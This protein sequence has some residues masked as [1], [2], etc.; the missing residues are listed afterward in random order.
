MAIDESWA[1]SAWLWLS[2]L[3]QSSGV[4]VPEG[5]PSALTK[6]LL[7]SL[8][9][10]A[11]KVDR[12]SN[13]YVL[14]YVIAILSEDETLQEHEE[15]LLRSARNVDSSI[16]EASADQLGTTVA[17]AVQNLRF[18]PE[19][20]L[21]LA[22]ALER[23]PQTPAVVGSIR[24]LNEHLNVPPPPPPP[25]IAVAEP[26]VAPHPALEEDTSAAE[27]EIG[28]AHGSHGDPWASFCSQYPVGS[29]MQ[30][31][32]TGT[33]EYGAFINLKPGID[34]LLHTSEMP[35]RHGRQVLDIV[36]AGQKVTIR[37]IKFDQE[38]HRISLSMKDVP[39]QPS[40]PESPAEKIAGD[41]QGE[42]PDQRLEAAKV[43]MEAAKHFLTERNGTAR[44]LLREMA[45]VKGTRI[46]GIVEEQNPKKARDVASALIAVFAG[47]ALT[48]PLT[49]PQLEIMT[50]A[51]GA[52]ADRQTTAVIKG[53]TW[54]SNDG[55]VPTPAQV[56]EALDG[57]RTGGHE[58]QDL[59]VCSLVRALT[60]AI[61]EEDVTK[62]TRVVDVAVELGAELPQS[63]A[64]ELVDLLSSIKLPTTTSLKLGELR[65]RAN[66][67]NRPDV[68]IAEQVEGGIGR[69]EAVLG[70]GAQEMRR[71]V[72]IVCS[73]SRMSGACAGAAGGGFGCLTL[74]SPISS[75]TGA[76]TAAQSGVASSRARFSA[77]RTASSRPSSFRA[78]KPV[79]R[80]SGRS[81]GCRARSGRTGRDGDR[82]PGIFAAGDRRRHRAT[83]RPCGPSAPGRRRRQ[84][85][86]T[87]CNSF[88][89]RRRRTKTL[90]R[91]KTYTNVYELPD[92]MEITVSAV[93]FALTGARSDP[94]EDKFSL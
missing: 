67:A 82:R 16:S 54:A 91:W 94:T 55:L 89:R 74:M 56:R 42:R 8:A 77:A 63:K 11:E 7:L 92:V 39:P 65:D 76:P 69:Q 28:H 72:R 71:Q 30:G 22:G 40:G 57:A 34:G 86:G 20:S 12:T 73:I 49:S 48:R 93:L 41:Q 2:A 17:N 25:L 29:I 35:D 50:L 13:T 60:R 45:R 3:A 75:A 68:G 43:F 23:C 19:L 21:A 6:D 32:V 64:G 90:S 15:S 61:S 46:Y 1:N 81:R 79:R 70:P 53:I 80:S 58:V 66:P 52:L 84:N 83:A 31:R 24:V 59:V 37:I 36:R 9:R 18:L 33:Q 27:R 26:A 5:T 51:G 4:A 38:R 87:P 14:S 10:S 78:G 44:P 47:W 85:I 88:L 62:A